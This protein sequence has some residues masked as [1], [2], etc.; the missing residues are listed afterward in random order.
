MVSELTG[1]N[2]EIKIYH[3]LATKPIRTRSGSEHVL[4]LLDQFKVRGV[5]G[6]HDVLVLPVIGPHLGDMFDEESGMIQQS[7]K[8]LVRQIALGTSFMHGCGIVHGG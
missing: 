2:N 1:R 5:N 4:G 6:E 8:S 7:I 3:H